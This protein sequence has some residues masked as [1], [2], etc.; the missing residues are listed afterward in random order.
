M[1][2]YSGEPKKYD[3]SRKA[4]FRMLALFLIT[5]TVFSIAIAP[6]VLVLFAYFYFMKNL[7]F[8]ILFLPI[9]L[10]LNFLL[11]I[12]STA[13]V[14]GGFIKIFHIA[15]EEG[16]Y[17][18]YI[19]DNMTFKF[20]LYYTLY[21]PTDKLLKVFF[22]PPLYAKYLT[23]IGAKI[24]KHVFFGGRNNIA[25]PCVTEIGPK[26]LIGGGAS[27]FSHLGEEKLIIKKV[28][29]GERCLVGAET[30]IMPGVVM[31][32]NVVVGGKSLVTKNQVLKK[33]K[34]YGGVPAVE[35]KRGKDKKTEAE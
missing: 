30:L 31:E 21:R 28:K 19:T 4:V 25:D 17:G 16:E 29:I 18:K 20:S 1:K 6:P 5:I 32:D 7:L 26:T 34:M 13:G 22:I 12:I 10:V 23:L 14:T 3:R 27:I 15:Y 35:I 24:G 8:T 2:K 11:L 33:G 9:V